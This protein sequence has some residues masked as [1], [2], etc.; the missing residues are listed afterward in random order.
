M[1]LI[2]EA[3]LVGADANAV[4]AAARDYL[5]QTEQEKAEQGLTAPR[6][7]DA[8]LPRRYQDEV[9]DPR[10]AYEGCHVLVAE[11][12]DEVVGLVV[13]KPQGV[14][15]EIKRLW[16]APRL[17]GRGIGSALLDAAIA[18]GAG[19]GALRLSVWDWRTG[20][21]RLYESRGFGRVASWDARDRLLCLQRPA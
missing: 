17:R 13:L 9:D 21:I 18:T 8:P 3:D 15:T 11:V 20:A 5:R 1:V 2:R 6:A 16:A 19:G 4:G 12:D 7:D 10:S 14:V